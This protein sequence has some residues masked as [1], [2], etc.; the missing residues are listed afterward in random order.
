MAADERS[1]AAG[2]A[3]DRLFRLVPGWGGA[4]LALVNVRYGEPAAREAETEAREIRGF[5]HDAA[6]YSLL[7]GARVDLGRLGEDRSRHAARVGDGD[8]QIPALDASVGDP[9]AI[10]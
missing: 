1:A 4:L 2:A 10:G 5:T 7:P 6:A 9:H 8:A 3:F